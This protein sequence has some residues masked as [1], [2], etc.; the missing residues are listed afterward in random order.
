VSTYFILV[1]AAGKARLASVIAAGG[2]LGLAQIAVGDGGGSV[3]V[4]TESSTGLVRERYRA[5]INSLTQDPTNPAWLNAELIIP[6]SVGGWWV[7]EIA[8]YTT[9]GT[10]F[11]VGNYPPSYKPLLSDGS[12]VEMVVQ[13]VLE[14]ENADAV[15]LV[16]DPTAVTATRAWV[17]SQLVETPQDAAVITDAGVAPGTDVNAL[18]AALRR[19]YGGSVRT[20]SADAAL[21]ANDAGMILADCSAASRTHVL[22]RANAANGRPQTIRIIRTDSVAGNTLTFVRAGSDT[23]EGG[24]SLLLPVGARVTLCSDGNATWRVVG[25]V[26]TPVAPLVARSAQ[27]VSIGAGYLAGVTV[28]F[29]PQVAGI[30]LATGMVNLST[31]A[32][33][34]VS[35]ALKVNGTT[36]ASDQTLLSQSHA[37]VFAVAAGTAVT[38]EFSLGAGSPSPAVSATYMVAAQ[39]FPSI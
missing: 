11:A 8:V 35:C 13:P 22:P 12:A 25:R 30:V 17:T 19:L 38:V 10:L 27:G 4:P 15:T 2:S 18:Q 29:T 23:V 6:A 7:R 16:I 31:V 39:F 34:G 28:S 9:D 36:L 21:G 37:G 33:S 5:A 3:P 20:L 26:Q 1:T 24:T 32:S 14:V